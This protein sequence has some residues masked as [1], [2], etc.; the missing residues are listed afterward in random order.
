MQGEASYTG[1]PSI[2]IRLQ[3]CRVGCPWC[4]TKHSWPLDPANQIDAE[5]MMGKSA[6]PAPTFA[7]LDAAAIT[8]L[9]FALTLSGKMLTDHAVITGGEPCEQD[10]TELCAALEAKGFT[11]QVETSGTQPIRVTRS[12]WVTVSP[13]VGM[14]GGF[15][16]LPEALTR[17]NEVKWPVGKAK[18]VQRALG[19]VGS[20]RG[21]LWLQPLS[22]NPTATKVCLAQAAEHG[23]RVS[24]QTHK[25]L[26]IR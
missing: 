8:E 4:D 7:W 2:F 25:F 17:A 13:K 5:Q 19:M 9:V 1:T 23:L 14:P 21:V 16:V 10:L 22:Q 11:V 24:L 6:D 15:L 3:G 12:T 20:R 26:G 18:D